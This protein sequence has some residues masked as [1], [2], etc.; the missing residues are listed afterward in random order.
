MLVQHS[1]PLK[2][3]PSL[4]LAVLP[5]EYFMACVKWVRT[6]LVPLSTHMNPGRNKCPVLLAWIT[7]KILALLRVS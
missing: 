7:K 3:S 1:S 5:F 4:S 6:L 2:I